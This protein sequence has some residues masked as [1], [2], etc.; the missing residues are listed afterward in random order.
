MLPKS[1]MIGTS[2]LVLSSASAAAQTSYVGTNESTL[3]R[4][5]SENSATVNNGADGNDENVSRIAQDGDSN[6]VTVEQIGDLNLS[7]VRQTGNRNQV[8][9]HQNGDRNLAESEQIGTLHRSRILQQA[10]D[11]LG[12]IVQSHGERN[13]GTID[14]SQIAFGSLTAR[15]S[16]RGSDNSATVSQSRNHNLAQVVQGVPSLLSNGNLTG[17]SQNHRGQIAEIFMYEG[18]RAAP[19]VVFVHQENWLTTPS[20][21]GSLDANNRASV[22]LRGFGNRAQLWQ[23]GE[24]NLASVSMIGGGTAAGARQDSTSGRTQGNQV[25]LR[26]S[27]IGLTALLSTGKVAEGDGQGNYNTITQMT[28]VAK[29]GD[30]SHLAMVWQRGFFDSSILEQREVGLGSQPPI[31][32]SDGTRGRAVADISQRAQRGQLWLGQSGDNLAEVTQGLGS[33][34]TIMLEQTDAGDFDTTANPADAVNRALNRALIAQYGTGNRIS[35]KQYSINA[36]AD[37]YQTPGSSFNEALVVQGDAAVQTQD[38]VSRNP[39]AKVIQGGT[40]N[41]AQ[42]RQF[43]TD[44][45]ASIEQLGAGIF[46]L[47]NFIAIDQ[48]GSS[49]H[50]TA[51]QSAGVGPSKSTDPGSGVPGD[52]FYGGGQRSSVIRIIQSNSGNS[53]M[54]EQRGRGQLARIEQSGARN[55]AEILQEAGATNATAVIRQTGNDNSYGFTQTQAGNYFVVTQSGSANSVTDIVQRPAS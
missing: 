30:T 27:G 46:T 37:I 20:T 13:S 5:G 33:G 24:N 9:H 22:A 39:F 50:A 49:N 18:S 29:P 31:T 4:N 14:Q 42:A 43:G 55:I 38:R 7:G 34:G 10:G 15:L 35:A 12:A 52:E 40:Y 36:I 19:N 8:T 26:Q 51:R 23:E 17:V 11:N 16:Q 48:I 28:S 2:L 32:Y 3:V 1:L 47:S 54:V 25:V 41:V 6:S 45:R 44:L 21:G 53:A